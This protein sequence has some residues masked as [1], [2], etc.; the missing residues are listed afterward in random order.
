MDD[1]SG[2]GAAGREASFSL[3]IFMALLAIPLCFE[4]GR[5]WTVLFGVT[6]RGLIL[7]IHLVNAFAIITQAAAVAIAY[8]VWQDME[9]IKETRSGHIPA[10]L[11]SKPA[12][13]TATY[14]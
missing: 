13:S 14:E 12:T 6:V 9:F 10:A 3:S 8:D 2:P 7:F 11:T 1:G 4:V 5:D